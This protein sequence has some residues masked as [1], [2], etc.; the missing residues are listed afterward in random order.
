MTEDTKGDENEVAEDAKDANTEVVEH[1]KHLEE[2]KGPP[3]WQ[4]KRPH[5]Q[6]R[7]SGTV[8]VP[9][10]RDFGATPKLQLCDATTNPSLTMAATK[11]LQEEKAKLW[12]H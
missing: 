2:T 1:A 9:D 6:L 11:T 3:K 8:A 5:E 7:H 4:Y 12:G 10:T